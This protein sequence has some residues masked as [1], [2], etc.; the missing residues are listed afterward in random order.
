MFKSQLFKFIAGIVL[1]FSCVGALHARD[2]QFSIGDRSWVSRQAFIESGARCGTRVPDKEEMAQVEEGLGKLDLRYGS[3]Y[4]GSGSVEIPV[5]FHVISSGPAPEQGNITLEQIEEQI[6]VLN[7]SYGG[8][9][10]GSD[11]SFRFT[12]AGVDRTENAKWFTM[13]YGSVAEQQ[14]KQALRQGGPESLNIYSADLGNGLLGWAT[15]PWEYEKDPPN[16]GV[17]ILFSSVPGGSAAPYNEGDTATHEVGHWL[18]LLHTFQGGCSNNDFIKD[19]PAERKPASGCPIGNDS[20]PLRPG[21]DP[22]HNFMNYSDDSC[23]NQFTAFQGKRMGRFHL[24][25]RASD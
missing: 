7:E 18:G 22:V 19:T 23:M 11:T 14:A 2:G 24:K 17:V 12:L 20:C 3:G 6:A 8:F 5:Y 10:G 15:F 25:W 16:D 21:Q 4:R 1:S 13:S 9:T